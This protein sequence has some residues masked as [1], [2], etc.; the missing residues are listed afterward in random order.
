MCI[1]LR[2]RCPSLFSVPFK[3]GSSVISLYVPWI[4][5]QCSQP[6]DHILCW[7]NRSGREIETWCSVLSQ[8]SSSLLTF[9]FTHVIS[10][11]DKVHK[12]ASR[13]GARQPSFTQHTVHAQSWLWLLFLKYSDMNFGKGW[14]CDIQSL[15]HGALFSLRRWRELSQVRWR[16]FFFS[17]SPFG[18]LQICSNMVS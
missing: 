8:M 18:V 17:S 4:R 16:A 14:E 10:L 2:D 1:Y 9:G 6:E 11:S 12:H 15:I 13:Q 3:L 5:Q 7:R